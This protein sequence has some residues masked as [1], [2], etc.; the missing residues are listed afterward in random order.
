MSEST[1][2]ERW[3]PVVGFPDYRVSDQGRVWSNCRMIFR[4]DG[5]RRLVGGNMI[6]VH[7]DTGGYSQVCL[8]RNGRQA[9]CRVHIMVLEA[10]VGPCPQGHEACHEDGDRSNA[11]LSNLRWD[12]RGANMLDRVRHGNHHMAVR[13]HCNYGHEYT[14]ENTARRKSNGSRVCI[15][16]RRAGVRRSRAAGRP[17]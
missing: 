1:S 8:P 10:F 7:L 15:E 5:A 12:T 9:P 3:L 4:S 2:V 16:C 11:R 17:A 13:T 6:K 14:P